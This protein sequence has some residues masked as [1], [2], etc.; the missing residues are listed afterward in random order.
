MRKGSEKRGWF[1]D[2]DKELEKKTSEVIKDVGKK[3]V[4]KTDLNTV[5]M[6]DF[7]RV[8][9]RFSKIGVHLTME[10]TPTTFA[11][12]DNYPESWKIKEDFDFSEVNSFSLL[13]TTQDE[14]RVGDTLLVNHYSVGTVPRFR[15]SFEFCEGEHYHRYLGWKR[16]YAKH[17]L[18]EVPLDRAKLERVHDVLADIVRVWFESHLRRDREFLVN[19]IKENYE[20]AESFT[21]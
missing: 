16:H 11:L 19:H 21:K 2:L 9:G 5:L 18:L 13:D 8:W 12:F 4:I 10:P 1:D 3:N 17:I 7:L 20:R 15:M 14:G 6:E